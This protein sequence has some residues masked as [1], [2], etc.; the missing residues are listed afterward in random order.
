MNR[1]FFRVLCGAVLLSA[2]FGAA[3][4]PLDTW[5]VVRNEK[6]TT[7]LTRGDTLQLWA[8][9]DLMGVDT[10]VRACR[11]M[12]LEFTVVPENEKSHIGALVRYVSPHNWIYVGCDLTTDIFGYCYWYVETPQGRKRVA[13][14][15]AKLYKD[16]PRRIQVDCEGEAILLRV[17]GEKVAHFALPWRGFDKA[18]WAGFRVWDGGATKVYDVEF[19]DRSGDL[20]VQITMFSEKTKKDLSSDKLSVNLLQGLP[21]LYYWK[22]SKP[23]RGTDGFIHWVLNGK[24]YE[25]RTENPVRIDDSTMTTVCGFPEI[26]VEMDVRHS[27]RGNVYEW[28]VLDIR[29]KGD[30]RVRT[31]G[32]GDNMLMAMP[33]ADTTA[34]LAVAW[35]E[36]SDRFWKLGERTKIDTVP[37]PAAIVILNNDKVA[38]ALDNNSQ[39][40]SKQFLIQNHP[41][42]QGWTEIGSN[43]WIYR[44]PDG[45]ITELPYQKVIFADDVNGDGKVT[46]QDGA[47]ALAEVYPDPYG[48]EMVRSSNVTITMNFASEG[49][50]PFLR[51]LDNVKKVYYLTDG[52]GQMLELK[53]Y[54]SEGHDSGHPDYAGHYNERAA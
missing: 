54:Q 46:W 25:V 24:R 12:S 38:V 19:A 50:Y 52:F 22:G 2:P 29:E 53:G 37:V 39:Y 3:A 45:K 15:I 23:M 44:G 30:F 40:E 34:R 26:Q 18:G 13:T 36:G 49:Q 1:H 16:Y 27:V 43:E 32:L 35:S 8:A 21:W 51:Q 47:V 9:G 20:P 10:S 42:R 48:A 28:R 11:N 14:D 7:F 4:I 33:N 31:I 6:Q 41:W 5:T 17:D